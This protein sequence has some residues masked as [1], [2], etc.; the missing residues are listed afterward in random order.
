MCV[1]S[2]LSNKQ[3]NGFSAAASVQGDAR[4]LPGRLGLSVTRPAKGAQLCVY[5]P[6]L[7]PVIYF[8][9][10]DMYLARRLFT[11]R[12]LKVFSS[13]PC[14]D[15]TT[16]KR[17]H[18]NVWSQRQ[19]PSL[20][21]VAQWRP[22]LNSAECFSEDWVNLHR[23][24]LHNTSLSYF[25]FLSLEGSCPSLLFFLQLRKGFAK[26]T[27]CINTLPGVWLYHSPSHRSN[28]GA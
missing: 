4:A 3:V 5:P 10:F 11:S 26:N 12:I 15:S 19:R 13:T 27:V 20:V 23:C 24:A 17:S 18:E 16:E 9:L 8:S 22:D 7:R 14:W 6:P 25:F 2:H 21:F 28:V 1:G